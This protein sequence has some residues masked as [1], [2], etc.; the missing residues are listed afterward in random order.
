[1]INNKRPILLTGAHRSGTTWAGRMISES[2][3][4]GYIHEPFNSHIRC[5]PSSR[6]FIRPFQYLNSESAQ[7][8][9][10]VMD[11]VLKFKFPLA[12]NVLRIRKLHDV[13]WILRQQ[14]RALSARL[15]RLRPLVKDPIAL[16]SSQWLADTYDMDVVIM[17][18]HPAAFCSSLLLKKWSFQFKHF[19]QQSDL[20]ERY[21][22]PF[23]DEIDHFSKNEM[24]LLDQAVLLWNCA[25]STVDQFMQE[26]PKW[27]LL[28]HEDL[29]SDPVAQFE[30]LYQRLGIEFDQGCRAA[31]LDSSGAHNPQEQKRNMELRR[32]SVA[33]IKNWKKRLSE[34]EIARIRIGT[35][36]VSSL[37]YKELDW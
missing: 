7:A 20:I 5:G 37:F 27:V 19:Q 35:E 6:P 14:Q 26:N 34:A 21:L 16:Y 11:D 36:R 24:P 10:N 23:R 31:V 28:K 33:N 25:Y 2:S 17:L 13:T 8:Y 1:M 15:R 18:R 22:F 9:T 30:D 3:S 4:I 29:S 32:D 12:G